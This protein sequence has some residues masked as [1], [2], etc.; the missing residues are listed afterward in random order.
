MSVS[1]SVPA[2]V[3]L[4]GHS[5]PT[6]TPEGEGSTTHGISTPSRW[7]CTRPGPA[8]YPS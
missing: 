5:A 3:Q 1:N 2:P 7:N 6:E 4:P 8:G